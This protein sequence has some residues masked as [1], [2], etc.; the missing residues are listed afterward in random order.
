V[1]CGESAQSSRLPSWLNA[2]STSC[3]LRNICFQVYGTDALKH[4]LRATEKRGLEKGVR[5][6]FRASSVA[7]E[8]GSR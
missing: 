3:G 7:G 1:V 2:D 5:N 6:L 4:T 8:A